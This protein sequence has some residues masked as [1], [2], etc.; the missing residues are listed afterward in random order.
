MSNILEMSQQKAYKFEFTHPCLSQITVP[1]SNVF[2]MTFLCHAC[3]MRCLCL[4]V[5]ICTGVSNK[6]IGRD[7]QGP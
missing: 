2:Y 1:Q 5:D 7:R 3:F 4:N 6:S